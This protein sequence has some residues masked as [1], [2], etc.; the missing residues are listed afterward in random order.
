MS[1]ASNKPIIKMKKRDWKKVPDHKLSK[2]EKA[3]EYITRNYSPEKKAEIY[4]T[5]SID[6]L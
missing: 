5:H 1:M 6:D 2:T 3:M 4:Q